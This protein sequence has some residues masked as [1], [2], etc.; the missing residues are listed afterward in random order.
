MGYL[1]PQVSCSV[2]GSRG[3]NSCFG[4]TVYFL[5]LSGSTLGTYFASVYLRGK[6]NAADFGH[7]PL[8]EGVA[9]GSLSTIGTITK[10]L[11]IRGLLPGALFNPSGFA[12]SS[13]EKPGKFPL[14]LFA[15]WGVSPNLNGN[16]RKFWGPGVHI[17]VN[18][19]DPD[20]HNGGW[21]PYNR[22]VRGPESFPLERVFETADISA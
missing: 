18:G 3:F 6:I 21:V 1:G 4:C 5:G 9:I 13:R 20:P 7:V 16:P 22:G 10:A 15:P 14:K 19:P 12:G 8:P 11:N 17:R 2:L